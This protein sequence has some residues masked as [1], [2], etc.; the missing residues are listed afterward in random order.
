MRLAYAEQRVSFGR[1]HLH[2]YAESCIDGSS[3]ESALA[4]AGECRAAMELN[5]K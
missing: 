4:R 5:S 1:H 3:E 2:A